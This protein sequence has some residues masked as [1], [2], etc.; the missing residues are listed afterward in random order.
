MRGVRERCGEW[1]SVELFL[2]SEWKIWTFE[3]I[4]PSNHFRTK[5]NAYNLRFQPWT[6]N[7]NLHFMASFIDVT[8]QRSPA[9]PLPPYSTVVLG[10]QQV[11]SIYPQNP[12]GKVYCLFSLIMCPNVSRTFTYVL[13]NFTM[14]IYHH[15]Y[16]KCPNFFSNQ[17]YLYKVT[18]HKK[19]VL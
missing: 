8:W 17:K 15:K 6:K 13:I 11:K 10:Q 9:R 5:K 2:R 18:S 7:I 1:L 4:R 3:L 16:F 19:D 12:M 14:T